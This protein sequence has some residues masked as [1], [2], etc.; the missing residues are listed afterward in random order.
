MKIIQ[1]QIRGLVKKYGKVVAIN[2]LDLDINKGE[3][4]SIVGPSGCGKSTLL[5]CIAGLEKPNDGEIAIDDEL[6][7]ST[8]RNC[9]KSPDKR[10]I[11]FVFQNYALWPHKSVFE[12]VAYPLRI[13]K[14]CKYLIKNEVERA[15]SIVRLLGKERQYPYELSGGQQ[16]RVALARALIMKPKL[17]LLDEPLS[18]LDAKLREDMQYE[19]KR[20]QKDMEITI[21]HVT[22]DQYEAMG[23]SDRIAVMNRGKL[24]QVGTPKELYE[25]PKTEFVAKFIGKTNIIHS[26]VTE[27]NGCSK[28]ALFEHVFIEDRYTTANIGE[29]VI[30]SI[31]PEDISLRKEKGMGKGKI[32]RM[33]YRGNVI[34]YTIC[35]ENKELKVQTSPKEEYKIGEEVWIHIHQIKG[36]KN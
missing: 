32:R 35:I 19:I 1:A 11:G 29:K 12:N 15:L 22:H 21:I 18:N 10:Q 26:H 24:I 14:K 3:M 31:R 27:E 9:F 36:V 20:I 13:R 28:L 25:H 6:V 5:S 34:E 4:L 7:F 30:L 2:G 23:I 33:F 16:Q 17:L 8:D